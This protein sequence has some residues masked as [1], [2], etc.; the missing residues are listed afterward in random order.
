MAKSVR[1]QVKLLTPAEREQALAAVADLKR[2]HQE[3]DAKYGH[4]FETPSWEL[5]EEARLERGRQLP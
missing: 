4:R 5:L 2:L 3:L 1:E